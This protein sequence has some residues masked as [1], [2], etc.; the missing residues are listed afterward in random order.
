M[1]CFG[2]RYAEATRRSVLLN[3]TG[4]TTATPAAFT[5]SILNVNQHPTAL[6]LSSTRVQENT[7]NGVLVAELAALD[8]DPGNL[9]FF[10]LTR[11][12]SGGAFAV[13]GTE[14]VV[15]REELLDYE[16]TPWCVTPL[17]LSITPQAP[18]SWLLSL[19]F[20]LFFTFFFLLRRQFGLF[21]ADA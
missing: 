12:A 2:R 15:A 6:L 17:S 19:S 7:P 11:N 21:A 20:I 5:V 3:I 13:A 9:F 18:F 4:P 14:L 1:G 10:S 16:T 8:P